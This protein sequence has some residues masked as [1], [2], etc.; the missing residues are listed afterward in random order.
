MRVTRFVRINE[1][2]EYEAI[3]HVLGVSAEGESVKCV[4]EPIRVDYLRKLKEARAYFG[5]TRINRL[6]WS[7]SAIP[8]EL[9]RH[10]EIRTT[11]TAVV[12]SRMGTPSAAY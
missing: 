9:S 1:A 4:L 10:T 5:T 7:I 12:M 3:V 6:W 8:V 2:F 11:M